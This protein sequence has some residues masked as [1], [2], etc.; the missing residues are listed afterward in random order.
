M[1]MSVF[2]LLALARET[3]GADYMKGDRILC[4][5]RYAKETDHMLEFQILGNEEPYGKP[6]DYFRLFLT[7]EAYRQ[8]REKEQQKQIRIIHYARV[9]D[10]TLVYGPAAGRPA[11]KGE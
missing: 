5:K 11:S 10:Q 4:E 7:G 8:M 1:E 2:E 3:Q 6:G 9:R